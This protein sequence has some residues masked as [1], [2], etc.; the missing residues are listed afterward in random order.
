MVAISDAGRIGARL[1][2]IVGRFDSISLTVAITAISYG[3]FLAARLENA[4]WDAS[5]LVHAGGRFVNTTKWRHLATVEPDGPGYD[6]QFFYMLAVDPLV[7]DPASHG[8]RIDSPPY[9]QQRIVYPL[10][11]RLAAAGRVEWLPAA[12]VGVNFVAVLAVAWLGASWSRRQ[13]GNALWGLLLAGYPGFL[14]SLSRDT[15]EIVA[16]A[17]VLGGLATAYSGKHWWAAAMFSLGVLTRE[18]TLWSAVATGVGGCMGWYSR[19]SDERTTSK[20][21]V[22]EARALSAGSVAAAAIPAAVFVAWQAIL[23]WRWGEWPIAAGTGGNIAAPFYGMSV[24]AEHAQQWSRAARDF[25][26]GEVTFLLVVAVTGIASCRW[27]RGGGVLLIGL[28]G[29]VVLGV[30][31]RASV[32]C[33]DSAFLRALTEVHVVAVA[34]VIAARVRLRWF[35]GAYALW[36]WLVIMRT[37]LH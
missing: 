17:F 15:A 25:W 35:V 26:W 18:T 28:A 23:A 21:E 31:L 10:L 20:H 30:C 32:W 5:K 14:V 19:R 1:T 9:R 3:A 37:R 12:M 2:A 13:G 6:G 8:F 7:I 22:E 16:A 4:G 11:A 29:Y 33:E 27:A 34:A 36:A 24:V